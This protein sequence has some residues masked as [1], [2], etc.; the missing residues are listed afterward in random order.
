MTR[1]EAEARYV[2][3]AEPF[4]LRFEKHVDGAVIADLADA[5]GWIRD[6]LPPVPVPH[7][8]W[9]SGVEGGPLT[10]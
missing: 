10:T 4:A 9:F 3:G 6:D 7:H 1:A 5:M 8:H 2:A